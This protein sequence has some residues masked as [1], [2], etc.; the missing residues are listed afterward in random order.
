MHRFGFYFSSF[1]S[2]IVRDKCALKM[3]SIHQQCMIHDINIYSHSIRTKPWNHLVS[4]CK[5]AYRFSCP[6]IIIQESIYRHST[7]EMEKPKKPFNF[8]KIILLYEITH[9]YIVLVWIIHSHLGSNFCNLYM[10]ML[11]QVSK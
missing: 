1:I 8:V 6:Q 11:V 3:M 10:L 9:S 4:S 2:E 7:C 5:Y